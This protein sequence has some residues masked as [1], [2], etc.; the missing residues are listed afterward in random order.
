MINLFFEKPYWVI[1]EANFQI[2]QEIKSFV[3][4]NFDFNKKQWRFKID[5]LDF[6]NE[7]SKKYKINISE[8]LFNEYNN[9]QQQKQLLDQ[10][11]NDE[12]ISEND[13]KQLFFKQKSLKNEQIQ[14][15]KWLINV[16]KGILAFGTGVGKTFTALEAC[17]QLFNQQKTDIF[18]IVTLSQLTTQWQKEIENNFPK[19]KIFN[20]NKDLDKR[21]QIYDDLKEYI[22][23]KQQEP[24]FLIT[25]LEKIR[26]DLEEY[27]K[28]NFKTIIIDEASKIKSTSLKTNKKIS[29]KSQK[30]NR[31]SLKELCKKAEYVFA[32]TATPVETSYYNLFGIFNVI[33]EDLFCGGISRFK[34]RYFIENFFGQYDIINKTKINE[35]K[36]LVSPYIFS[37]KVKLNVNTKVQNIELTYN[38]KDKQ[39][40]EQIKDLVIKNYIEKNKYDEKIY[41]SELT[42]K[43][44]EDTALEIFGKRMQFVDFPSIVYPEYKNDYSPKMNWVLNNILKMEGKTIIFDSRTMTTERIIES[45]EK[46]NI[47]YF[48]VSGELSSKQKDIVI[49]NFENSKDIKILIC[50]DSLAYGKNLQFAQNMI[51]FN[52]AFN[53]GTLSQRSGRI[54]RRGQNNEVKIYIL[55]MKDTIEE[56]IYKK[57]SN[58]INNAED[59]LNV[60][61]KIKKM[62]LI[63][64]IEEK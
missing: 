63:S 52:L 30:N 57:L 22:S 62:D 9:F 45:F 56:K 58:R 27:E 37:K 12:K 53:P 44:K 33:N 23:E 59:V 48:Y 34:Q 11:K 35:L 55:I 47:K 42:E 2:Q 32:L 7:Y 18:L 1:I 5:Y 16:K 29:G 54:I 61:E 19:C 64:M 21:K 20:A 31:A 6:F 13:K 39:K 25:N 3:G 50:T 14:G 36:Q 4:C 46:N 28:F 51:F 60:K 10:I 41:D 24:V 8:E 40:Y 49:N 26:L 17:Y 15:Y 43:L 38:E